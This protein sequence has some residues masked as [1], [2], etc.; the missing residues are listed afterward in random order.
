MIKLFKILFFSLF[1][2]TNLFSQTDS[3]PNIFF[4]QANAD[5]GFIFEHRPSISY[6]VNGHIPALRLKFGKSTYGEKNWEELYNFPDLGFGYYYADLRNKEVLGNVNALFFFIDVPYIRKSNF[7]FSYNLE[8]GAAYLNKPFDINNN[9]INTAIG[10]HLN[11]YINLG[12]VLDLKLSDK[13]ILSN[14]LNLTHYSNGKF[15]LPNLGLN[16]INA[17]VGIKYKISK[18][19]SV[20]EKQI[21]KKS[22]YKNMLYVNLSAGVQQVKLST[23]KK[24]LCNSLN[25]NYGKILNKKKIIGVGLDFFYNDGFYVSLNSAD[26]TNE[27]NKSY[28]YRAGMHIGTDMV[29]NKFLFTIQAGYY[30]YSKDKSTEIV[31]N[32]FGIIYKL[33]NHLTTNLTLKTHLVKADYVEFG[34]GYYF[35]K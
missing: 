30:I 26:Y 25:I 20:I 17:Q 34:L 35:L 1:C 6:N 9:Y 27:H 7:N 29:F 3:L 24:Y 11:A 13:I 23:D 12:L 22:K 14:S 31:Y 8:M 19:I 28:N 18:N 5:Y 21:S 4:V 33:T 10:S 16:V 2:S 15:S 32:R